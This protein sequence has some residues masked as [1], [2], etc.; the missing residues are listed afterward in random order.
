MLWRIRSTIG[1]DDKTNKKE[2]DHIRLLEDSDFN[3]FLQ[4]F[5]HIMLHVEFLYAKLQKR[6][7]DAVHKNGFIQQFLQEIHI[8]MY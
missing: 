4:L 8:I 3:F 2:G 5:H 7:T 6:N 1:Y